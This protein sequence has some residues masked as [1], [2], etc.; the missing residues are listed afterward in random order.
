MR[1]QSGHL[2]LYTERTLHNNQH[3]V[4][5]PEIPLARCEAIKFYDSPPAINRLQL[6]LQP[7]CLH[8]QAC[9]HVVVQP[10]SMLPMV[11]GGRVNQHQAWPRQKSAEKGPPYGWDCG[12]SR[13]RIG[14]CDLVR[15]SAVLKI[16]RR[17]A[18]PR[19]C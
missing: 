12:S 18:R 10:W 13:I 4:G 9:R 15:I 16:S 14:Y 7:V 6:S 8:R 11:G 19:K 3:P 5:R 17:D 1:L 2:G